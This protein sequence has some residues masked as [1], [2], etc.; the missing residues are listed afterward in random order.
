MFKQFA[1]LLA[2]VLTLTCITAA[3]QPL[4]TR[5]VAGEHYRV[6]DNPVSEPDDGKVH[7]IEFFLYSC[8]HCFHLEPELNAWRAQLADDVSFARVPVL[9]GAGGEIYARLYYAA[10]QLDVLDKVHED[11]FSAIH[12]QGRRLLEED[13]IRA[14]MSAHGIDADAF[15]KAFESDAVTAKLRQAGETMRALNVTATPSLGVAGRY[16]V[17]G[18]S[19][20]NNQRM[21]DVADYLIDQ[22]RQADK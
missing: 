19:A 7:V 15:M 11:I 4:M 18:R 8:P 17:S 9:F 12:E 16:Y 10:E 2:L 3:A 6:A 20:G 14:F 21:F 22:Q 5:Y 1:G 13:D